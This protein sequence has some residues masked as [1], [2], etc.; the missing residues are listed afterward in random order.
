MANPPSS[1]RAR[2]GCDSVPLIQPT[3]I[4]QADL[5]VP[6]RVRT[7]LSYTYAT[8]IP[9]HFKG[10]GSPAHATTFHLFDKR[11]RYA[12]RKERADV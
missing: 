4:D 2:L 6:S 8:P 5:A 11:V 3:S 7:V 10:H 1:P 12:S 9:R